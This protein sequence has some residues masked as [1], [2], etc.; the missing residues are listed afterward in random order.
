MCVITR[1]FDGLSTCEVVARHLNSAIR[2]VVR[3]KPW[4]NA[5]SVLI[6]SHER[7]KDTE[8]CQMSQ[9]A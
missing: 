9:N 2:T 1:G 6:S 7:M 4:N 5:N 3:H 8:I